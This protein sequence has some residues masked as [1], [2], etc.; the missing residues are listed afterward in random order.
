MCSVHWLRLMC[1]AVSFCCKFLIVQESIYGKREGYISALAVLNR[2]K[3]NVFRQSLGFKKGVVYDVNMCQRVEMH[4][5]E[6]SWPCI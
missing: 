4:K 6:A 3:A 1:T 5:P 2:D